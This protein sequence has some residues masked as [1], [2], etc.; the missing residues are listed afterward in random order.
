MVLGFELDVPCFILRFFPPHVSYFTLYFLPLLF[1][2]CFFI[3]LISLTCPS[4]AFLV[5]LILSVSFIL[6]QFIVVRCVPLFQPFSSFFILVDFRIFVF[7]TFFLPAPLW[8]WL[9]IW[10]ASLVFIFY[11]LNIHQLCCQCLHL[12]HIPRVPVSTSMTVLP[13]SWCIAI[14]IWQKVQYNS[15]LCTYFSRHLP[16]WKGM[17]RT[18]MVEKSR[19]M[20]RDKMWAMKLVGW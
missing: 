17:A 15:K 12:G 16:Y 14:Q 18:V 8:I 1:S 5:Y 10:I 2:R 7:E 3:I 13:V 20:C 11:L 9:P 4:L 6:C 19:R